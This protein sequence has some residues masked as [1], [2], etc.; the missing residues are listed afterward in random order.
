MIQ[1]QIN[2]NV[3]TN[4][5][6]LF[7]AGVGEDLALRMIEAGRIELTGNFRGNEAAVLED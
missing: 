1:K 3:P 6:A 7:A 5:L 4:L 2:W